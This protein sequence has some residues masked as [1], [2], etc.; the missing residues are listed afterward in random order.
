MVSCDHVLLKTMADLQG[1]LLGVFCL[2]FPFLLGA[3][4][5][6]AVIEL[7]MESV[8]TD[9]LVGKTIASAEIR[10]GDELALVFCDNSEMII[11]I[12]D[13]E[14]YPASVRFAAGVFFELF[15]LVAFVAMVAGLYFVFRARIRGK[16]Q[17]S[18]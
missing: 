1:K 6:P 13:T 8:H 3:I 9:M 2:L 15:G 16:G 4:V 14:P 12:K 10:G 7:A 18:F 5:F 11:D 17:G